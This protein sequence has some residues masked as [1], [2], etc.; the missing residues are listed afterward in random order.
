MTSR[1]RAGA[2]HRL[3]AL[4]ERQLQRLGADLEQRQATSRRFRSNIERLEALCRDS[5]TTGFAKGTPQTAAHCLNR[6]GYT[7]SLRAMIDGHRTDLTLHEADTA[8]A[9]RILLGVARRQ[10]GLSQAIER[11]S[12][13]AQRAQGAREQKGQDEISAQMWDRR[14]KSRAGDI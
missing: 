14:R 3:L 1:L 5:F 11:A 4:R 12:A 9:R 10:K 13:Q 8:V 6:A 7:Q 2:L